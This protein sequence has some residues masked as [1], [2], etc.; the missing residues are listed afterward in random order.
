[1]RLEDVE[2]QTSG[3]IVHWL[4]DKEDDVQEFVKMPANFTVAESVSLAKLRLLARRC[5]ISAL[6]NETMKP[7]YSSI[8]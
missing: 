2:I 6:Q 5:L 3:M 1:M 7:I 8:D 4:Y